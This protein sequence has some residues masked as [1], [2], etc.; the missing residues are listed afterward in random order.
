MEISIHIHEDDWGM[1]NVYPLDALRHA[2][3]DVQRA[4]EEGERNRAPDGAGWTAVHTVEAPTSDFSATGLRLND[5]TTALERLL[6]RVRKFTATACAGFDP[7]V[8]DDGGSYE[9]DASCF[10]FDASCFVKLETDGEFVKKIWFECTTEEV[11]RIA[12][13]RGALLAIDAL[14]PSAIADYWNDMAGP[15]QDAAFLDR[16]FRELTRSEE[17]E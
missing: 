16:Y 12:A 13:L 3:A 7:G 17:S 14:T 15:I 6:P 10:G 9:H 4:A 11:E 1:R 8:R 2:S 5:V